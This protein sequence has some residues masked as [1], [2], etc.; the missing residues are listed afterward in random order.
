MLNAAELKLDF[1]E[2]GEIHVAGMA[3]GTIP[4]G[5]SVKERIFEKSQAEVIMLEDFQ[6]DER[7]WEAVMF[8]GKT[9]EPGCQLMTENGETF[10]RVGGNERYGHGVQP[11]A[12][13]S[14]MPGGICEISFKGRV[15][16]P[17][18]T[19]IVYLKVYDAAGKDITDNIPAGGGW[20]YS[21]FSHTHCRFPISLST[22]NQ[23]E[24]VKLIYPV[25]QRVHGL[26]FSICQWRGLHADC[27][28]YQMTCKGGAT[29]RDVVFDERTQSV[30]MDG[31]VKGVLRS[32]ESS[33]VL[34][35]IW[36]RGE[37]GEWTVHAEIDDIHNPPKPRAL[38]VEFRLPI[39]CVDGKWHRLWR[40]SKKIEK[41]KIYSLQATSVGSH[42]VAPYPFTSIEKDGVKIAL[43]APFDKPAFEDR[44]VDENGI[45]S[46]TAIGLLPRDGRGGHGEVDLV[47]FTFDGEWGFRSAIKRYY[48]IYGKLFASRTKPK[49][50]GTWLWPIWPGALPDH[51]EDFGLAFWE[52]P[53]TMGS[54]EEIEK[55]HLHGIRAFPY[56]EA[57]GMRQEIAKKPGSEEHITVS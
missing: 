6:K 48:E 13:A 10:V 12:I 35:S 53:A 57:W 25:P 51:P 47:I 11:S 26:R 20:T 9:P 28:A 37:H 3:A 41:G 14:V 22:S 2:N 36:R 24:T 7:Q 55:G 16:N 30:Q 42:G 29:S 52:A 56:T 18:S 34:K 21:P 19:F 23:W 46:S 31:S 1:K 50:E 5:F 38:D 44:I 54:K 17:E 49:E 32:H 15:P 27:A 39:D 45:V 43:G 4:G 33:L 8:G 40:D